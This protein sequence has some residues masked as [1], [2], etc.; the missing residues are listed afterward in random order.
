MDIRYVRGTHSSSEHVKH[1]SSETPPVNRL[2]VTAVNDYLRSPVN[3]ASSDH[4]HSQLL[5]LLDSQHNSGTFLPSAV[6]KSD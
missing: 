2:V 4:I 1:E 3:S 6:S 5:S